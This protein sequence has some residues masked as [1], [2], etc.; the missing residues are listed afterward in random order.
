MKSGDI[1]RAKMESAGI[2]QKGLAD[3]LG[4]KTQSCISDAL[5][6]KN[7]MRIDVF[8]KMMNALG[9]E[10]VVRRGKDEEIVTE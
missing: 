5:A 1:V 2:T 9:Y 6:R 7:G 3:K 8:V 4:Y 10:V